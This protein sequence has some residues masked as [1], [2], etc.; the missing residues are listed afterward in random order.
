V[1]NQVAWMI[2]LVLFAGVLLSLTKGGWT[3]TGG[4]KSWFDAKFKGQPA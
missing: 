3:G 1:S 4:A 2:L